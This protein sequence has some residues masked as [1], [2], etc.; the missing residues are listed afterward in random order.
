VPDIGWMH[1]QI[2][3]FAVA[4]LVAGV[5]FRLIALTGRLAFSGPAATV[6]LLAG[7]VAAAGAVHSGINAHGPVERVPGA[8]DAVVEHEEW[9]E[10]TR[11]VF[12]AVAVLE[13]IALGLA[14]RPKAARVFRMG[15]GAIGLV[16]LFAL[17]EAAEHGGELVYGYAGGVGIRSG[18]TTDTR[19]L[20]L[21]GLYHNLAVDRQAG[22]A[23][24]AARLVEEMTRR[25]P[26]D[27]TIRLLAVESHVQDR[28]DGRAALAALDALPIPDDQPRLVLR[29]GMLRA[30]AYEAAGTPDSVRL[31]LEALGR[32]FPDNAQVR[33]RLAR[34]R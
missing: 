13:L 23:E 21:A 33:E 8:R 18:D 14:A 25:W 7:T 6:L 26:D 11:N 3:H 15:S 31:T 34:L 9:G 22:R 29:A 2:V 17:Y 30:D 4:L 19:R 27:L 12:L 20:L 24:D 10:R 32:R 1:P 5:T 28:R 16:G